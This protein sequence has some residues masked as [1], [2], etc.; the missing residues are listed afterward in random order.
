MIKHFM[1]LGIFLGLTASVTAAVELKTLLSLKPGEK[2]ASEVDLQGISKNYSYE[3]V[4]EN[5]LIKSV[6]IEFTDAVEALKYIS[7]KTSGHCM[8]QKQA[9]H[10]RLNRFYFFDQKNKRRYELTMNKNIIAILIQD[11]PG[12]VE[13]PGCTLG[14]FNIKGEAK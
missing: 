9:G 1:A 10:V 6:Q 8:V 7:P 5:D 12:A 3:I 4:K 11:M 14:S 13:N 2:L